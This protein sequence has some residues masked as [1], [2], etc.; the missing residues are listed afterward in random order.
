MYSICLQHCILTKHELTLYSNITSQSCSYSWISLVST[1]RQNFILFKL[2]NSLFINIHL[3]KEWEHFNIFPSWPKMSQFYFFKSS[4][5]NDKIF[6]LFLF[7][8]KT[9]T[10]GFSF[11]KQN[12][13]QT[14]CQVC[15]FCS[16]LPWAR[17]EREGVKQCIFY[18]VLF[19]SQF[20]LT[21][22]R[23]YDI[24]S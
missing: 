13:K 1:F 8:F 9:V 18:Q 12:K 23:Q 4:L 7:F 16:D 6:L 22:Y 19:P 10:L 24:A 15:V 14:S 11:F 3:R 2:Q 20:F 21:Q 5:L 17:A